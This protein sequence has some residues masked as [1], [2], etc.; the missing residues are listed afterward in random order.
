M[1]SYEEYMKIRILQK[2]GKSLRAIVY[3]DGLSGRE[4]IW[5]DP[6]RQEQRLHEED[7][8]FFR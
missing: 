5:A 7:C 3:A 4:Q 6:E 8:G 2:Q 1:V